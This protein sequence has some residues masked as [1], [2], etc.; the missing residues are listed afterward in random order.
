MKNKN[1]IIY[2]HYCL[3]SPAM[4]NNGLHFHW[5]H[6]AKPAFDP[7]CSHGIDA[8]K[9]SRTLDRIFFRTFLLI[10]FTDHCL[11]SMR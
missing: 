3:F 4:Y 1:S 9:K 8:R 10:F 7:V 2:Y 11:V 6:Y 5:F